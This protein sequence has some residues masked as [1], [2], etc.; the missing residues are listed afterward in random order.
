VGTQTARRRYRRPRT[1]AQGA[2]VLDVIATFNAPKREAV[3]MLQRLFEQAQ[4]STYATSRWEQG[5][6]NGRAGM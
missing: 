1:N 5:R 3:E 4:F 6:G 2:F